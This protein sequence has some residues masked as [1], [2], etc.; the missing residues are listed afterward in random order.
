MDETG[1]YRCHVHDLVHAFG[2]E[3]TMAEDSPQERRAALERALGAMLSL[4]D[5]AHALLRGRRHASLKGETPR[6]LPPDH[7]PARHV[8]RPVQAWLASHLDRISGMVRR[9]AEL[10][11]SEACWE[12]A[13][14]PL[15]LFET[16]DFFS[17][18]L[19]LHDIALGCVRENGNRRGEAALLLSLALRAHL[20]DD[21]AAAEEILPRAG[22]LFDEVG[23]TEGEG[24]VAWLRGDSGGFRSRLP[25]LSAAYENAS[26][27]LQRRGPGGAPDHREIRRNLERI[28]RLQ[29]S[30]N[31]DE[32][33]RERLEQVLRRHR[34]ED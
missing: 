11:L 18:W 1:H 24:L 19:R 34:D 10:G 21:P 12:L 5:T 9:S 15:P 28:M 26:A 23:D 16:G 8:T 22:R 33:A 25:T 7:S 3:R 20:M 4:T 31:L 14:A 27:V 32:A 13:L 29:I 6:W 2:W 30:E 17:E